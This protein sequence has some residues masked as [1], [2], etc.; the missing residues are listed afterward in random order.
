[1]KT[2]LLIFPGQ[3]RNED[4][5]KVVRAGREHGRNCKLPEVITMSRIDCAE[6]FAQRRTHFIPHQSATKL[7]KL[8]GKDEVDL[9]C[10]FDQHLAGKSASHACFTGIFVFDQRLGDQSKWFG[11]GR[12]VHIA[13]SEA[14]DCFS[15]V[16]P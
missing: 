10:H 13:N 6:T 7:Y 8:S 16:A 5:T 14:C 12:I 4:V 1:M 9:D 15:I 2:R 3:D 11:P